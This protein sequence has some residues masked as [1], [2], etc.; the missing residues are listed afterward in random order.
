MSI[1]VSVPVSQYTKEVVTNKAIIYKMLTIGKIRC[2]VYK[3]SEL[4]LKL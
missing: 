4:S 2:K 1:S 3:N